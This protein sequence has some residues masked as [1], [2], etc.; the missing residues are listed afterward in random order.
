MGLQKLMDT[1]RDK[2]EEVRNELLRFIKH[3]TRRNEEICKY[4]AFQDGFEILIDILKKEEG[5]IARDCLL[6]IYNMISNSVLT[7]KLFS[8]GIHSFAIPLLLLITSRSPYA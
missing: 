7:L 6:I 4:I 5:V 1:L 8:Q 3:L 2:R